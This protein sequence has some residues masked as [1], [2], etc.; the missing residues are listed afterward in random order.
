MSA[1]ISQR[2]TAG[3]GVL[4]SLTSEQRDVFIRALTRIAAAAADPAAS[5][6]PACAERQRM[7][8]NDQVSRR[9]VSDLV[10]AGKDD[11]HE[12]STIRS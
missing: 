5:L 6:R 2:R 7:T 3:S 12:P 11:R 1:Q 8:H 10:V 4:A 9:Q